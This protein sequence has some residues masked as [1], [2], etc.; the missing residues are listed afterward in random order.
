M[1]K[2]FL[3]GLA[4]CLGLNCI[5][6]TVRINEVQASN[7]TTFP[8][9]AGD[10]DDW[11]EIYNAGNEVINLNAWHLSDNPDDL[12]KWTFPSEPEIE[13]NPGEFLLLVADG[14]PDESVGVQELHLNFSLKQAGEQIILS[15]P[16]SSVVHQ[17]QYEFNWQD[18]SWGYDENG[19]WGLLETTSPMLENVGMALDGSSDPAIFSVTGAFFPAPITTPFTLVLTAASGASIHYTLDGGTP[20]Q[21]SPLYSEGIEISQ[22][23]TVRTRTFEDG[24]HPSRISSQ[25]YLFEELLS[26]TVIHISCDE[27]ELNGLEGMNDPPFQNDEIQVDVVFFDEDGVQEHQQNMGLKVHAQDDRAQKSFRLHARG[28]YGEGTL[29]LPV[30]GDREHDGYKRLI[31]RNAGND[32]IEIGGAGLRDVLIHDLYRSM[33]DDYGVSASKAVNLYL[34]GEYWGVYNLRERQDRHWLNDVY[35]IEEDEVDFLERTAGEQDTRDELAG[36]WEAYDLFEQS[37]IDLGLCD[38]AAYTAFV[39]QMDLRNFMDYQA[40]E[41]YI[42]NQDWLSNNM[43]FYKEHADGSRWN[44]VLWDTDWGFGTF[45]PED[46]HSFPE[47]NALDF[48][49]S[50]WGGWTSEVETELFTNLLMNDH[51]VTDFSTRSADLMNSCLKPERVIEQLLKRKEIIE[52]DVPLQMERWGGSAE[53]WESELEYMSSF[54]ADRAGHNRL[55]YAEKFSLGSVFEINLDQH[56]QGAG[57]MEVNTIEADLLPWSGHYFEKLPV[58]LKAIAQPGYV[59]DH[60]EGENIADALSAEIFVDMAGNQSLT[61]VYVELDKEGS[62]IINEV[63]YSSGGPEDAGDWIELHNPTLTAVD[64]SDWQFCASGDCFV[65][66]SEA[67]LFAGSY[68]VVP[69]DQDAF[70]NLFEDENH[71]DVSFGFGL[72]RS[73]ERLQLYDSEGLLRDEVSYSD[74]S[75]WP[76]P[77]AQNHSI[78]LMNENPVNERGEHWMTRLKVPFGSPGAI[79]ETVVDFIEPRPEVYP[80]PFQSFLSVRVPSCETGTYLITIRDMMGKTVRKMTKPH[81]RG[82]VILLSD[83]DDLDA[84][85]YVVECRLD[86]VSAR[87]KVLKR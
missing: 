29:S 14:E 37:A 51:F 3:A 81:L 87:V 60:W 63:F 26:N 78:E 36:N 52:N 50:T 22:N 69:Q 68:V 17:V 41:I 58:R 24:K 76:N 59:F 72:N 65:F 35:G 79:N 61:A 77:V 48:A 31:L 4:F 57:Y 56:P 34:N 20:D 74:E 47:W 84:G 7:A 67:T 43:K 53:E 40:L 46:D 44:W 30:F 28:E 27:A 45:Y 39:E 82:E 42:A 80:N 6:Q 71:F 62:P 2:N 38:H 23:T 1:K 13:L 66:P 70:E 10:F 64:L 83:L 54:I 8:D 55:H 25:V 85:P 18:H 32:G 16:T 11:I 73:G 5:A 86:N 12:T 49:T 19:H 21:S 15:G 9:A 33:D 75:P